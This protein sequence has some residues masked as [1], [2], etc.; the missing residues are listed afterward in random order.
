VSPRNPQH[1]E[2]F[3][4]LA[5]VY[6][7]GA[8]DGQDLA[9][10]QAHLAQGCAQCARALTDGAEAL[11]R[12]ATDL[13][14]PPPAHIRA[15]VLARVDAAIAPPR[16]HG[17][18]RSLLALRWVAS[19]AVVAAV[20]STVVTGLVSARYEARLGQMAR[21]A[22]QLR[23]QVAEQRQAVALL[24]DPETRV[25]ALAGLDPSPRASGRLIWHDRAGGVFV[26]SGLPPAPQGKTYELWAI[27]GGK[28]I[29]A[30]VFAVDEGGRSNLPV[31]PVS[32]RVDVFAVTLEPAP[33]V[34]AP[35]GPMYLAS[36]P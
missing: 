8:L 13:A 9:R 19:V 11:A 6:A 23:A 28:P 27:V 22:A 32:G 12:A 15:R 2:A 1:D 26:A 20:I 16:R 31:K 7:L 10:F 34:P 5:A 30:G 29:P 4:E 24:R 21:E 17:T 18:R 3:D 35:T 25:V 33:G 14:E 36:K